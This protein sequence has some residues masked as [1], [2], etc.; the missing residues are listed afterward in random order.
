[1]ND[2]KQ[3]ALYFHVGPPITGGEAG[4]DQYSSALLYDPDAI[5][6][7]EKTVDFAT[8]KLFVAS[9]NEANPEYRRGIV[10]TRASVDGVYDRLQNEFEAEKPT[11]KGDGHF[12][13]FM[14]GNTGA[15]SLLAQLAD[16]PLFFS[17]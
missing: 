14:I 1:M 12:Y 10:I 3:R 17:N 8:A 6:E 11:A 15:D 9:F 2:Q 13:S 7:A 16:D 5:I 4:D